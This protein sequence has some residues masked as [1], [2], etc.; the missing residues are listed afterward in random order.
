MKSA[1]QLAIAL[2]LT[3]SGLALAGGDQNQIQHQGDK[4][5]GSVVQTQ[6]RPEDPPLG[7]TAPQPITDSVQQPDRTRPAL[8]EEE[9]EE[10]ERYY[11]QQG[12]QR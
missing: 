3:G 4:G 10:R 1:M 8:T 11:M 7:P 9:K 5:Q 12:R 2:M 6:V